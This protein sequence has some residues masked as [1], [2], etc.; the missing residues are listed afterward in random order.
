MVK[1]LKVGFL[2]PYS[3]IYP[4]Y[5]QHMMGGMLLG[6]GLDPS[7]QQQVQ[8]I[9]AYT[10]M[11]DINST[12]EAAKK[13]IFFERV[14]M[15]SG[16]ISFHALPELKVL[17]EGKSVLSF[18]FNLGENLH[19]PEVSSKEIFI[20]SQMIWQS[21]FALGKWAQKE[22]GG[23][24]V[25]ITH[26]YESGYHLFTSF[27]KGTEAAGGKEIG[28][29]V[30]PRHPDNIAYMDFSPVFETI[31]TEQPSFVHAIF[32]GKAGNDFLK[33]WFEQDFSQHIPLTG[34]ENM[35]YEDVLEDVSALNCRFYTAN[36]WSRDSE[37]PENVAFVKLF[38]R[39]M[40]QKANLF[41]MMGYETGMAI[42]QIKPDLD[43][44][45]L[46]AARNFLENS[47]I[48]GPRA[49]RG[50]NPSH[51]QRSTIDIRTV[52]IAENQIYQTIVA[53]ETSADQNSSHFHDITNDILTGWQNPYMC[54]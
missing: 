4:N 36:S 51:H 50:F 39:Q 27:K 10:N 22:F 46:V 33:A 28:L 40:G 19:Y 14:D 34:I 47:K 30:I 45:D 16:L 52:Q 20:N 3:G 23:T 5:A 15:I 32:C 29:S 9:P 37:L 44:G 7:T 25:C 53:Q 42:R 6:M 35:A 38:E 43:K 24:G 26:F 21:E 41:A 1:T 13:L 17:L 54:I 49:E 11:G 8:F 2:C 18:F 48:Y 12:M 31:R